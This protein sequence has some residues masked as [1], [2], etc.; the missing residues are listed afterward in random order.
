MGWF[1]YGSSRHFSTRSRIPVQNHRTQSLRGGFHPVA[2]TT[3]PTPPGTLYS[4]GR[5]MALGHPLLAP[6]KPTN[7]TAHL[8]HEAE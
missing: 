2:Y 7:Q 3:I 5:P 6:P 8:L 1:W 4:S